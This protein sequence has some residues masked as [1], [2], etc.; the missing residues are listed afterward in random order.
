MV[1]ATVRR[2]S[3][4]SGPMARVI[5][6]GSR[7]AARRQVKIRGTRNGAFVDEASG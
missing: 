5:R 4:V 1:Q 6:V 2:S 3:E 7:D